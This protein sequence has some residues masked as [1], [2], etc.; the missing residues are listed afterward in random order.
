M[1]RL[2]ITKDGDV[3]VLQSADPDI[4]HALFS[5]GSWG[6]G[7]RIKEHPE[8]YGRD[9]EP[10]SNLPPDLHLWEWRLTKDSAE[11]LIRMSKESIADPKRFRM[12][13]REINASKHVVELLG[14][15]IVE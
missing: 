11:D 1:A 4:K 7:L 2:S 5:W 3:F 15:A 8:Y 13:K 6:T 14:K 12:T 10:G 9:T